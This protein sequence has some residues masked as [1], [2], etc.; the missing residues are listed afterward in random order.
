MAGR[1]TKKG[2]TMGGML[3]G[4]KNGLKVKKKRFKQRGY[5]YNKGGIR[6]GMVESGESVCE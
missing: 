5:N 2:R 4:V 3:L 1:K 6:W